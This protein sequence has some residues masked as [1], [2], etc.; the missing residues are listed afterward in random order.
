MA[1]PMGGPHQ[2]GALT[3]NS[4]REIDAILCLA[5]SNRLRSGRIGGRRTFWSLLRRRG[6]TIDVSIFFRHFTYEAMALAGQRENQ[7]LLIAIVANDATNPRDPAAKGR[8]RNGTAFPCRR[9]P[10]GSTDAT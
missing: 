5:K 7:P 3:D 8:R 4:H 10:S 6:A 2:D 9:L 1:E